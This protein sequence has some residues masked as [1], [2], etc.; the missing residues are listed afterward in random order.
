MPG[1][2]FVDL[3]P[4]CRADGCWQ[5]RFAEIPRI[6]STVG[7]ES[8]VLHHSRIDAQAVAALSP[9]GIMLSGSSYNLM[10]EPA[11]DPVDGVALPVF[12][13][14]TAA[15]AQLPQT[16]VLGICFGLQYLMFAAGGHLCPLERPRREPAFP[17][18]VLTDDPLFTGI[19]SPRL[20]ENHA[21]SVDRCAPGYQVVARS[22]DGIE[23]ARHE[24]LPRV[25]VQFHPEYCTHA[26]ATSDG[27]RMLRNWLQTL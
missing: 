23:A 22:A 4:E 1:L 7:I 18:E 11:D 15:L 5:P 2:L 24:R 14:L 12:A 8:A 21:W 17:I 25:G 20:V 16:P 3:W 6:A 19:S 27:E 26:G 10:E 13:R 9:R